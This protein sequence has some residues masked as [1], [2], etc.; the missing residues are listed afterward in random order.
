MERDL[1]VTEPGREG[2]IAPDPVTAEVMRPRWPA[3]SET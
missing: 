1:A 3:P 2:G